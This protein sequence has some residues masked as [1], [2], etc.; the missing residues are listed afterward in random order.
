MADNVQVDL[1]YTLHPAQGTETKLQQQMRALER[2]LKFNPQFGPATRQIRDFSSE[3]DRANQ[4][5]ITLGASFAVLSGSI[6]TL[7]DIVRSTIEV[8]KAFTEINAVFGLGAQNLD[9][10]SKQLF[11]TARNTAQTFEK[12][13]LAAKEF[14]RQGLSAE[15]TIKRTR[16]A[17]ILTRLANLDVAQ[18]VETLTASINGFQKSALTSTAIINKLAT[19]DAAFA[20][21][22]KDLAEGL[23]RAGAAASDAG[24]S[25]DQLVGLITSAQQTTARGGSVIGNS[26]KTIFTRVERRDTIEAFESLGVAVRDA[27]GNMLSALPLLQNFAKTYDVLGGSVKKQAAELVGG[28]FQINILKALLGDL[29]RANGI[30]AQATGVSNAATDEAIQRNEALNKSLDSMLAKFGVTAKQVGANIGSLSFA[31]PAKAILGLLSDNPIVAMLEDASGKAE[32]TGGKI[33]QSLLKGMGSAVVFGL[34]PMVVTALSKVIKGTVGNLFRDFGDIT[35]LISPARQQEAIQA[36]VVSLYRAGGT[37]L[38]Q[39]LATMTSLTEQ[40]ALLQRL[41]SQAGVNNAAQMASI[42]QQRGV[43]PRGAPRAAGGYIPMAEESAAIAAGIG[44]APP[45]AKAVFLPSFNRG[46]GQ[47][48]IVANTSEWVVPHM[49][50]GGGAIFN[51]EMVQRYGLPPGSTPVAAAG[52]VPNAAFGSFLNQT[53]Y[54]YPYGYPGGGGGG[55]G[56][57]A[58]QGPYIPGSGMANATGQGFGQYTQSYRASASY[59]SFLAGNVTQ[60]P[61]IAQEV[62]QAFEKRQAEVT[63][64]KNLQIEQGFQL[65]EKEKTLVVQKKALTVEE[66]VQ[67]QKA[68]DSIQKLYQG[69]RTRGAGLGLGRYPATVLPDTYYANRAITGLGG[70]VQFGPAIPTIAQINQGALGNIR[71]RIVTDMSRRAAVPGI[72]TSEMGAMGASAEYMRFMQQV[73][74]SSRIRQFYNRPGGPSMAQIESVMAA[75]ESI[76]PF[77]KLAPEMVANLQRGGRPPTR[78]QRFRASGGAQNAALTASFGLPFVGSMIDPGM[79]GTTSGMV[80]GGLSSALMGAGAGASAGFMFS[81]GN[82]IGAGIGGAIGLATGALTGVFGKITKSYEEVATDIQES[83]AKLSDRINSIN[84]VFRL[85]EELTNARAGGA[86]RERI[87]EIRNQQRAALSRLDPSSRGIVD[88]RFGNPD[89]QSDALKGVMGEQSKYRVGNDLASAVLGASGTKSF[90]NFGGAYG[91]KE[92][93]RV[94]EGVLPVIAKLSSK[95]LANLSAANRANPRAAMGQIGDMSNMDP[96]LAKAFMDRYDTMVAMGLNQSANAL[97]DLYSE[98]INKAIHQAS[99]MK[100]DDSGIKAEQKRVQAEIDTKRLRSLSME[101]AMLSQMVQISSAG[102]L[103]VNQVRQ[104]IA[105]NNPR[106][107]ETQRLTMSRQFDLANVATEFG[108]QRESRALMG[109]KGLIDILRASGGMTKQTEEL[110]AGLTDVG[111][112]EGLRSALKTP[113]TP[114][115][116]TKGDELIAVLDDTIEA[117]TLLQVTED[118]Q[119]RVIKDSNKFQQQALAR[120]RTRLGAADEDTG[121]VGRAFEAYEGAKARNDSPQ[122]V[123]RG[124][125]EY[126]MALANQAR[127]NGS[128]TIAG[129]T[130]NVDKGAVERL[131]YVGQRRLAENANQDERDAIL[132]AASEGNPLVSGGDITGARMGNARRV[133]QEG[134][135]Q[136]SFLGGF[137]SVIA[138]AKR[139]LM[140]FSEAGARVAENLHNSGV[141]AWTSWATG[142]KKGKEAFREFATS[143]LTDASRMFAS[144]AFT[145]VLSSIP[146]FGVASG[147][148]LGF[149]AGGSVPA[150]LTGGEYVFG[151]Q[152]A[153]AIG[154]DTLQRL[155]GYASGGVVR[156]GSGVRDDV[157]ARLPQGSFVIKKSAVQKLGPD[158]LNALAEGQVQHRFIGGLLGSFWGGALAG[159][160]AGGG[161]GYLAGGKKGALAGALIG[162]VGG[163]LYGASN[164][165]SG[166]LTGASGALS[167]GSSGGMSAAGGISLTMGQ[168]AFAG[169][170]AAGG[171]G[172]LAGALNS[173]KAESSYISNAQVPAYRA[174]L[175]AEQVKQLSGRGAGKQVF[176]E[177]NP[178][179]GYSLAGFD[180]APATRRWGNG[181]MVTPA[182]TPTLQFSNGGGVNLSRIPARVPSG[183]GSSGDPQV[184]ISIEINNN[185]STSS[186]TQQNGKEPFSEGSSGRLEKVVKG[187]VKE[188]LVRQNQP[189][190]FFAQRSRYIA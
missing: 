117:L 189:D 44:G 22:S 92:I 3:M 167:M 38:A 141:D 106:Y 33:A 87:F 50:G 37:A 53:P 113:Q 100:L 158:Y 36:Q 185:G 182:V 18:S 124:A 6:R 79:G 72:P 190:G 169:L 110:I 68:A 165:S 84:E 5:V 159:G 34:G 86:S 13:A 27:E 32:S 1:G 177:L 82:P 65:L 80:R 56:P 108:A 140:D 14:S 145:A 132:R 175:E 123:E 26:L 63:R 59:Q 55:I 85:D 54:G 29:A 174:Q 58:Y 130:Y 149:A 131:S 91:E 78:W 8:E 170:A 162:A 30:A 143:V 107:T 122:I 129:K 134:D 120:S 119:V 160:V 114:I 101:V 96:E 161:L 139:D 179:G 81:G 7:K 73:G 35:K 94:T 17:L 112:M 188:E 24:V 9:R 166:S 69:A 64:M 133:G 135:A 67:S 2:N 157:P 150:M 99:M 164:A 186:A 171:L 98:S 49:A 41:L 154:R 144:K 51:R 163:G 137:R 121:A 97:A 152:A 155:N 20:V 28:V 147:G 52:H 105:L 31:G 71:S 95:E 62:S 11:D 10:F 23:S 111:S 180:N 25:F 118:V 83:N 178:Q 66:I 40:A 103:K 57:G 4:R 93:K 90:L 39:Q 102:D 109:Q 173:P 115:Q 12:A 75:N 146:G 127:R 183:G 156:G 104:G 89:A 138:G 181:G 148:S 136:G 74:A 153:Q 168:K 21:S 45:S 16:D 176:L 47:R 77:G 125:F 15:E 70:V 76:E 128:V 172:M 19:V 43:V 48:G 116:T 60:P 46:G 142:A 61:Q 184:F 187:W 88:S 126:Q 42:L 151:P